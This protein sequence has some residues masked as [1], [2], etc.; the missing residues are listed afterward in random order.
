MPNIKPDDVQKYIISLIDKYEKDVED[1]V[2]T[3]T[4]ELAQKVKPELKGY[5]IKGKQLY[6]TGVYQSGWAYR[7]ISKKDQYQI[8]T[9]NKKKPTIVHLLEFGHNPPKVKADPYP[10]VIKTE[11]K[12]LQLLMEELEKGVTK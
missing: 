8:K 2:K 7:T 1:V 12:Y 5:S 6:R 9:Y 10:H 4:K 11:L 3:S